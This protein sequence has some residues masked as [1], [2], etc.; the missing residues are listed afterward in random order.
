VITSI[1]AIV[2]IVGYA[3]ARLLGFY[4]PRNY[5]AVTHKEHIRY[6]PRKGPLNAPLDQF[7]KR[8]PREGEYITPEGKLEKIT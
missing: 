6:V 7:P 2:L 5:K 8:P 1:I 4:T 3:M